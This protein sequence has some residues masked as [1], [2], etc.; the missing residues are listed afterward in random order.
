VAAL[1]LT[2]ASAALVIAALRVRFALSNAAWQ[3]MGAVLSQVM[4]S[5]PPV[6]GVIGPASEQTARANAARR[7][8]YVLA[9][10]RR[11]AV[12]RADA[13]S[14]GQD[15]GAATR[16]ALATEQRY[17]SQHLAAMWNRA[18]AAGKTDMAALEHGNLLGWLAVKSDRTTPECAAAS[19]RNFYA[20]RMPDIGFPG[21]VH[22]NCKCVPVAPWPGGKLLPSRGLQFARAA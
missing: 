14:K 7:A 13:R 18:S 10:T 6:T 16:D 9:A 5:P 1:L 3:A 21:T 15:V 12:A 4:Q 22:P 2:A 11:V 8:Q 19:G 20:S 17:Y